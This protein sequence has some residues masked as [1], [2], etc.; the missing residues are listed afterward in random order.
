MQL[1]AILP[2]QLHFEHFQI[3][4]QIFMGCLKLSAKIQ[5]NAICK[6]TK[7]YPCMYMHSYKASLHVHHALM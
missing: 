2:T 7:D 5:L 3:I 6:Q 1:L 4:M